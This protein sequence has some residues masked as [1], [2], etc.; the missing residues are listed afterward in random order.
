MDVKWVLT[1]FISLKVISCSV[2]RLY[3]MKSEYLVEKV[4][5]MISKY[6]ISMDTM[7]FSRN[8]IYHMNLLDFLQGKPV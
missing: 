4:K 5:V 6:V 2:E 1:K 3:F 8:E 7:N